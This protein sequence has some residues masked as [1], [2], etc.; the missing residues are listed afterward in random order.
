M[1]GL[2]QGTRSAAIYAAEFQQ[3][4]Y[5]LEWNDKAF[6]NR[7]RYGLKDDVKDLLIIM[8]KIETLQEFI[9]Q[10]ITCDNR[11]F[12][13]RQEK[14]FGWRNSNH[15]MI[16]TSS[17]A[18]KN[19][20]GLE[21]IQIDTTRHNPLSQ[22]EKHQCCREGLCFYCGSSKHKLPECPIKPKGLKARSATSMESGTLE[23]G[24][25]RSQ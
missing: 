6:I 4:T 19:V 3:L 8:P 23:N 13:R 22:G 21:P 5:D 12:E 25:V 10:A 16:S 9:T 2:H 7:F 11:L 14:R 18:E 17:A 1:Q 15:T 20:S 24:D